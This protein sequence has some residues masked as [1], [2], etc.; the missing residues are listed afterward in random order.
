LRDRYNN[1]YSLYTQ[2]NGYKIK[3]IR[4]YNYPNKDY[5]FKNYVL[6]IYKLRLTFE[7]ED[8]RNLI[9]KLLLNSLYGRFGMSPNLIE[10][11]FVNSN[12]MDPYKYHDLISNAEDIIPLDVDNGIE[13]IGKE[14]KHNQY[15]DFK[16]KNES[17][18]NNNKSFPKVLKISTPLSIFTTA[19]SRIF[20]NEFKLKYKKHIYYSDTDSLVMDIPL[21]KE[22]VNNKI[23]MFKL[24]NKVKEGVFIAPKTYALLLDDS[25]EIVKIKGYINK[26]ISFNDMKSLLNENNKEKILHHT[27]LYKNLSEAKIKM[28]ETI[29]SLKITDNKR[30]AIF[31]EGIYKDTSPFFVDNDE[32]IKI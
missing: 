5:L 6:K 23:G 3:V 17:K 31:N 4:G 9:C 2:R 1:I 10:Y 26:D 30:N 18:I 28:M 25:S 12:K 22:Y 19:Y 27:K 20:M 29:F 16:N 24:E 15:T 14:V 11:K 32:L 8:P 7:K 21:P 13:L